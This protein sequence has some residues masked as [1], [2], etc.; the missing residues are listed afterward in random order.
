MHI[1]VMLEPAI[2]F[3]NINPNGIYI[4]GTFGRG[5][6]SKA[7]LER[8]SANGTLIAFDQDPDAVEYAK[9]NFTGSNFKIIHDNF[10]NHKIHLNN[11]NISHVDGVLLDLGICSTQIDEDI[12][13]FSFMREAPLDMRMNNTLGVSAAQ[14]LKTASIQEISDVLWF[15]AE[16][17][18]SRRIAKSIYEARGTINTTLDLAQLVKNSIPYR[19]KH[20]H[21]ATRTFQA[22]RI[23]INDEL[24][25]LD[26]MMNSAPQILGNQG[27]LVV[28][29][30]HSL[31]DRIVKTKFKSLSEQKEYSIIAK[32]IKPSLAE[33]DKNPRSRSAI[34]RVLEKNHE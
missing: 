6:H 11:I 34:M 27:R 24:S 8:L 22:I 19:D 16:E 29:S 1:S 2:D 25:V 21:P 30:F 33:I 14:W 17:R 7:I 18:F 3:L 10:I 23:F 9:L 15:Y 26:N 13:G 32:K 20:K 31:E 4:D 28:I 5:G 12:R